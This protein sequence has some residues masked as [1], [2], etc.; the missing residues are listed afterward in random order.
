MD[1]IQHYENCEIGSAVG[2]IAGAFVSQSMRKLK[3]AILKVSIIVSTLFNSGFFF[4]PLFFLGLPGQ[5]TWHSQNM[6][7]KMLGKFWAQVSRRWQIS[8]FLHW[9][10][11]LSPPWEKTGLASWRMRGLIEEKWK[12]P[13]NCLHSLSD[14]RETCWFPVWSPSNYSRKGR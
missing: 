14:L 7:E 6:V 9:D 1:I 4:F 8:V 3:T 13:E 2:K 10:V 12:L 5:M 11:T